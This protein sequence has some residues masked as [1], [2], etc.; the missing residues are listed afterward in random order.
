MPSKC[1]SNNTGVSYN[2]SQADLQV[3]SYI[4]HNI[5]MNAKEIRTLKNFSFCFPRHC[6]VYYQPSRNNPPSGSDQTLI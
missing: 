4:H 3:M 1:L 5:C 6:S 2:T